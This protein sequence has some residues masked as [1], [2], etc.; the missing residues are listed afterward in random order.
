MDKNA[1]PAKQ[2][3]HKGT[4]ALRISKY[5]VRVESLHSE[6]IFRARKKKL[7]SK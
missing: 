3:S 1:I 2:F 6:H 4:K 7:F 5:F